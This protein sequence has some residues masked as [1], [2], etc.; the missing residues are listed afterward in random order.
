[1]NIET[2]GGS[3]EGTSGTAVHSDAETVRVL[4]VSLGMT[5]TQVG[6]LEGSLTQ[7]ETVPGDE[8]LSAPVKLDLG[9][10]SIRLLGLKIPT[11]CATAQPLSLNLV[12]NLTR[13]ELLTKGWSFSGTTTIPKVRCEGDVPGAAAFGSF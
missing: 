13:E 11:T 5:V 4:P 8:M 12:D 3:V 2:D 7:S 9:I 10:T 1:M 6:S